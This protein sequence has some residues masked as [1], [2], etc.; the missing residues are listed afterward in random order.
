MSTQVAAATTKG[1]AAVKRQQQQQQQQQN[2]R[3]AKNGPQSVSIPH[4]HHTIIVGW[5]LRKPM[6]HRSIYPNQT[7]H[8]AVGSQQTKAMLLG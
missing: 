2:L 1:A 7:V 5:Q 4:P 6:A 8:D 3:K